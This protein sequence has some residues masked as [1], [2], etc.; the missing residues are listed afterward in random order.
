MSC[1]AP[2]YWDAASNSCKQCVFYK[3]YDPNV[4]ACVECPA[5]T[6]LLQD[7]KC[8]ACPSGQVYDLE[9]HVCRQQCVAN[10]F[11]NVASGRCECPAE[12]P[13]FNGENC[14]NC[15]GDKYYDA[16]TRTC[17]YCPDGQSFNAS[18]GRCA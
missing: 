2:K 16:N 1:G 9:L 10:Q 12:E 18:L 8:V 7:G 3:F 17:E 6:P 15:Y 13:Y 11:F 14:F 4:G 5:A